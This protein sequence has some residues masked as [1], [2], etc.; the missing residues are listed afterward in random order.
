MYYS[1]NKGAT[2]TTKKTT[3]KTN[4]TKTAKKH[5]IKRVSTNKSKTTKSSPKVA[6]NSKNTKK[7]VSKKQ[8]DQIIGKVLFNE[9]CE[10]IMLK[11]AI[12]CLERKLKRERKLFGKFYSAKVI[13]KWLADTKE[14]IE[15]LK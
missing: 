6:K 11:G 9:T 3:K 4:A 15:G 2:M 7:S 8:I 12:I 13:D 1:Y 14:S 10:N 5:S